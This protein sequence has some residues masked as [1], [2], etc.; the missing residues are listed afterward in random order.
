MLQTVSGLTEKQARPARKNTA[1]VFKML[2]QLIHMNLSN[3]FFR[4]D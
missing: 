2:Q 1:R 4:T 3:N